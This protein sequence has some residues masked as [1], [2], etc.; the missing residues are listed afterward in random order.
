MAKEGELYALNLEGF[1]MDVGQPKDYL[2]G[3]FIYLNYLKSKE[4]QMLAKGENIIGNVLIVFFFFFFMI[5]I[6]IFHFLMIKRTLR[7][8]FQKLRS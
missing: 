8:K 3:T 7:L 1:W 4:P 2:A 6:A 5:F